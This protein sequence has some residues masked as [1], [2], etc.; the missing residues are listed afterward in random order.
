MPI[1]EAL[2]AAG[3]AIVGGGQTKKLYQCCSEDY[4]FDDRYYNGYEAI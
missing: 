1:G 4:I 2:S 3:G